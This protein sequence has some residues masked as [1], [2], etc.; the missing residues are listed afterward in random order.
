MLTW[1]AVKFVRNNNMHVPGF[2]FALGV[3]GDVAIAA[4]AAA[5]FAI[6]GKC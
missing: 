1:L 2:Y 5:A 3:V 6:A 4:W